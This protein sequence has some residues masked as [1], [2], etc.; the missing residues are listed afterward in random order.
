MLAWQS[1]DLVLGPVKK[2]PRIGILSNAIN[3][4]LLS[5]MAAIDKL[6]T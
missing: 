6:S 3:K 4:K 2:K 5:L 1:V